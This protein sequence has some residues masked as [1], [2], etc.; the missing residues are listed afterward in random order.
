M[1]ENSTTSEPNIEELTKQIADIGAQ[2][3][4]RKQQLQMQAQQTQQ[5]LQSVMQARINTVGQIEELKEQEQA[6]TRERYQLEGMMR[7]FQML[8]PPQQ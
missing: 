3:E 4:S 2:E 1:A 5:R 8:L 7:V 6:Q